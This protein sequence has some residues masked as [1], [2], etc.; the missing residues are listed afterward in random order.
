MPSEAGEFELGAHSALVGGVTRP[1]YPS[2]PKR[3]DPPAK[4]KPV[5]DV[6]K[7]RALKQQFPELFVEYQ[8]K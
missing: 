8:G 6:P 4:T 1:E 5:C 7:I 2:F 3:K